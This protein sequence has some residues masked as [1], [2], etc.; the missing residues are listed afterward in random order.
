VTH[1]SWPW[2]LQNDV[3]RVANFRELVLYGDVARELTDKADDED[4][5]Y[6]LHVDPGHL[7]AFRIAQLAAQYLSHCVDSLDS[8]VDEYS[9][10][11][12]SLTDAAQRLRQRNRALV[13]LVCIISLPNVWLV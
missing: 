1:V 2:C 3:E 4:D 8:R 12:C 10:Q 5:E 6:A 11:L 7:A 9:D 13:G